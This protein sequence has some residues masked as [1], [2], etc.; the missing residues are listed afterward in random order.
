MPDSFQKFAI[1]SAY[2]EGLALAHHLQMEGKEV[3]V[4]MVD[5]LT[6]IMEKKPEDP[7]SRKMR[8]SQYKG[9][10]DIITPEKLFKKLESIEDKDEW[11]VIFDFNSMFKYAD[12]VLA[13]GFSNG[14]FPSLLDYKLEAD[15]DFAK[16]QVVKN[17]KDVKVAEVQQFKQIEEGIGF[18]NESDEFWALKGN[19]ASASTLVPRSTKLENAKTALIMQLQEHKEDYERKGYIFERQIREGIESCPQLVYYNGKRVATSVD[20]ENKAFSSTDDSEMFG[21]A[22]NVIQ[23]TP[24]DCPLND[25]AFPEF[26]D[27]LARKHPGLFF[28]DFNNIQKDG[29]YYYLEYCS[30]RMG[31]DAVFAECDMT[32]SV[33]EYFNMLAHGESPYKRKYGVG[34][35]GFAMKRGED[36]EI[37]GGITANFD[38]ETMDHLWFF[39]IQQGEG[40]YSNIGGSF[41]DGMHGIDL[42]AFT[43]SSDDYEYA[44]QKLMDVVGE[45]SFNGLYL[46]KDLDCLDERVE[47][48]KKFTNPQVEAGKK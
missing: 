27:K 43:E 29:E 48:I 39:G 33:A 17:Y 38:D 14:L 13:M 20:I 6:D 3:L 36:G 31:Y 25:I 47:A 5:D 9:I 40:R 18:L 19:D 22:L 4:G 26:C 44:K 21:C 42:L 8:L 23:S 34:I 37:Q 16:R 15:R 41:G 1:V 11:F 24:M 35:R 46:R 2:G 30:G 10:L 12:K 45:F 28:I 7:K 32:G